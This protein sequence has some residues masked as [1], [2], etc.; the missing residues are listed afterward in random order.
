MRLRPNQ[1]NQLKARS[2]CQSISNLKL[3]PGW[4]CAMPEHRSVLLVCCAASVLI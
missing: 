1:L 2:C 3:V 4:L